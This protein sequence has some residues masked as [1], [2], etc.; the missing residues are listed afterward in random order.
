MQ[1]VLDLIDSL[2]ILLEKIRVTVEPRINIFVKPSELLRAIAICKKAIPDHP[3]HPVLSTFLLK[4]KHSKITLTASNLETFITVELNGEIIEDGAI[5]VAAFLLEK[6]VDVVKTT[7]SKPLADMSI[8]QVGDREIAIAHKRYKVRLYEETCL[9]EYHFP[10]TPDVYGE[11]QYIPNLPEKFGK[12]IPFTR[13][14]VLNPMYSGITASKGSLIASNGCDIAAIANGYE[15]DIE[16]VIPASIPL[17]ILVNPS[18]YI[19]G[20][21]IK[22]VDVER[23]VAVTTK[24]IKQSI[25]LEKIS[26]PDTQVCYF[27][28]AEMLQHLPMFIRAGDKKKNQ[29]YP[30]WVELKEGKV[31]L[32]SAD[33]T[34]TSYTLE[35]GVAYTDTLLY[36]E[37][38]Q[39]TKIL[40]QASNCIGLYMDSW[41]LAI[42]QDDIM[43][44]FM[45]LPIFK[46]G[47]VVAKGCGYQEPS[48]LPYRYFEGCLTVEYNMIDCGYARAEYIGYEPAQK[49]A[50]IKKQAEEKA[51]WKECL[52]NEPEELISAA[53]NHELTAKLLKDHYKNLKNF[54]SSKF[55]AKQKSWTEAVRSYT[56]D[57]Q[58][59]YQ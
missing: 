49:L 28:Q 17:D 7:D 57:V 12:L 26:I 27:Q 51:A 1:A 18:F 25:D 32:K 10:I 5:C 24:L 4:A 15:A 52:D 13:N 19:D 9:E 40:K 58:R 3:K 11:L 44:G 16:A 14:D 46:N 31:T 36:V 41:M 8:Q 48:T 56:F 39:V 53:R 2:H 30:V 21:S 38:R 42:K 45:P 6:I 55:G 29:A 37:I 47:V 34:D 43:L 35:T 59:W 23:K 22:F 20:E 54:K 33:S 50:Q